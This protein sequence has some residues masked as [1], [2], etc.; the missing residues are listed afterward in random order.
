M[1]FLVMT[2]TPGTG[3]P[4]GEITKSLGLFRPRST[5]KALAAICPDGVFPH[6]TRR[7]FRSRRTEMT[8]NIDITDLVG[9]RQN[10]YRLAMQTFTVGRTISGESTHFDALRMS[11]SGRKMPQ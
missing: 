7:P 8:L 3:S 4:N 10:S 2:L 9:S 11:L 1:C 6:A 5:D